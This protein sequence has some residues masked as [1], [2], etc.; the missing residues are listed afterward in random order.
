MLKKEFYRLLITLSIILLYGC[1]GGGGEST[2]TP[3]TPETSIV[4]SSDYHIQSLGTPTELHLKLSLPN[5]PKSLYLLLSNYEEDATTP[6]LGQTTNTKPHYAMVLPPDQTITT[7]HYPLIKQTKQTSPTPHHKVADTGDQ[8]RFFLDANA[9]KTTL[10]TVR[11][12]VS[13]VS[14]RLGTKQLSI[15][16][17][18]DSFDSGGGCAKEKCVTQHMIDSAV[19]TFLQVGED[20]DIYDWVTNIYGEEWGADAS[21]KYSN[22][23]DATDEITILL[24]DINNDGVP[25]N[26]EGRVVGFFWSKDNFHQSSIAGSNEKIMFYIDAVMFANTTEPWSIYSFW[27]KETLRALAHEFQ[28]MINFYQKHILQEAEMDLWIQEMLSVT[29]EDLIANKMGCMGGRGVESTNGSAGEHGNTN[30]RFP[31]FNTHNTQTLTAWNNTLEGYAQVNAFG[32]YLIRNYG[33]VKLLHDI[34]H[35]GY[36]DEQAII[37]AVHQSANGEDKSF[38]TLLHEWGVA[39]LLSDH[40]SPTPA[41][42]YNTGDF[43]YSTYQNSTYKMGSINFFNYTPPPAIATTLGAIAPH[44]NYY[45]C[46]EENATGEI[47]IDL[48][49][50]GHTGVT[51][52]AK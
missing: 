36:S 24:T 43:T 29:T 27:P 28:H 20:N 26:G 4:I 40:Q 2:T 41:K 7:T 25:H 21:A 33:G 14:T 39:V 47:T 1:G 48:L 18:D 23:I 38:D 32:A 50:D 37:E 10:A 3:T 52:I 45:Y 17:S 12:I 44:G 6:I 5:T 15:W 42:S 11:K 51:L 22:L 35:N 30:G 13:G 34:M 19:D 31:L 9:T 8:H 46:V 16:V 49:L